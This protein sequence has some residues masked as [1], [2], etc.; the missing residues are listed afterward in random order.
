MTKV[1]LVF[2][3][4]LAPAA[5]LTIENDWSLF[6]KHDNDKSNVKAKSSSR[7]RT[8]EDSPEAGPKKDPCA[9]VPWHDA[10]HE[11]NAQCGEGH[12]LD[13]VAGVSG[14]EAAGYREY[15]AE[16]CENFF[17]T[18][19]N[20]NFC[21]KK[22]PD[23]TSEHWCYVSPE[24]EA[25]TAEWRW[26]PGPLKSKV[27]GNGERNLQGM[28]FMDFVEYTRNN[29]LE[30]GLA[31]Q[32]VYPFFMYSALPGVLSSYNITPNAEVLNGGK[33]PP[34]LTPILAA[35]IKEQQDTGRPQ[36][37]GSRSGHPPFAVMQG[38]ELYWINFKK[39]FRRAQ[40]LGEPWPSWDVNMVAC[41]KG[42]KGQKRKVW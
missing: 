37:L 16:F 2:A 42:C 20:D 18:L 39:A 23:S 11:Y 4:H 6:G 31:A 7:S 40:K 24:C 1:A 41:V 12:E 36:F 27:C 10:Y 15:K 32:Y 26:G 14:V 38:N 19:P 28:P 13:F 3:A 21:L 25:I 34:P 5:A 8:A 9:C 30:I 29:T 22:R 33:M 17:L 35:H